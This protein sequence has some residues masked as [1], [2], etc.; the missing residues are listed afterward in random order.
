MHS[1]K[2]A[3]IP[4]SQLQTLQWQFG[5]TW[6]LAQVHLPSLTDDLCLWEPSPHSWTVRPDADGTWRAD[7]ADAEPDPT[8]TATI[9]WLTWHLLWWW[10][11]LLSATREETPL[12][13]H[14]VAWP[15]STAD[16]VQ[17][18][19]ALSTEWADVLSSLKDGD[20]ERPFAYPWTEPRPLRIA[21]AWANVE[22][23][24]N[25]AEIGYVRILFE[26]SRQAGTGQNP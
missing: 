3:A 2:D 5:L 8:P 1:E 14:E 12:A 18:L 7:W 9:G 11:G 10:S 6:R 23:M 13:H 26:A 4:S 21:L 20:L 24:K 19:E 17:R 16:T 25:I 15:G 22:L